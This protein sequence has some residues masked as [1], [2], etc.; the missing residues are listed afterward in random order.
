MISFL[1]FTI[2][3]FKIKCM[4]SNQVFFL[5]FDLNFVA[6]LNL[7]DLKMGQNLNEYLLDFNSTIDIHEHL[8]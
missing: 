1:Y 2:V 5:M 3:L 4:S 8:W 6:S 7:M